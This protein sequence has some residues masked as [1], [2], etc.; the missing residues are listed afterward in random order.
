M[1]AEQCHQRANVC[2]ANAALAP[3]ESM[4]RDFMRLAAQWR[5]IAG[6][7]CLAGRRPP[8]SDTMPRRLGRA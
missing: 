1:N 8:L 5:A 7:D 2:A 4:A 6:V 3:A